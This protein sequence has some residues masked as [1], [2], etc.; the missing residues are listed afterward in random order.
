MTLP[1]AFLN[2]PLAHR[3]YHDVKAGRP[4]NSRAAIAAAIEA[5]YGI[6]I[7][8]QLSR[9]N[10]AMVFH[11]YDLKRLTG[12]TGPVRMRSVAD[13]A[14]I[15]LIGRDEG[16]PTL[17][18]VL[19]LVDGK[20]PVLIEIKDQD[21]AM[22]PNVGPL[23]SSVIRALDGYEGP[24]ALMSFNPHAVRALAEGAPH[25]P[26]GLTTCAFTS[27]DWPVLNATTRTVLARIPDFDRVGASF[28]SHDAR[29]LRSE[30]V[31]DLKS[32]GVP[33]LCW[34]VRSRDEETK[35]REIADNVTFEGYEA[36][37]PA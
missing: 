34:T 15:P 25:I 21:G 24:V 30:R 13:L 37:I 11:D 14:E 6:E 5:G 17:A 1:D 19:T 20:V 2:V 32:K 10:V 26:R 28:I 4:E 3:A 33:I 9:D 8:V 7:D 35:A 16:I 31:G 36:T 27:E 23:E 12:V 29:D 18:E 22:G